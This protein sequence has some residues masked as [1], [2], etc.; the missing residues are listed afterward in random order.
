MRHLILTII[1][2]FWAGLVAAQDA[3]PQYRYILSQDVDFYGAD[4]S[5]LFDT[6][7]DACQRACSADDQCVAFTFN[8]RSSACFPKSAVNDQQPYV[9][10]T[11]AVRVQADVRLR[12]AAQ[13]R[14]EI[15]NL[16]ADDLVAARNLAIGMDNGFRSMA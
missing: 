6:N 3:I 4:R 14:A 10:A 13:S 2:F 9:G 12:V 11:S 5:A 8:R 16:S 1:A 15:L 7:Y